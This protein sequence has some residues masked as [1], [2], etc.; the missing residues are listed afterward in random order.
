MGETPMLT[1]ESERFVTMT[2]QMHR[3]LINVLWLCVGL[4]REVILLLEKSQFH[5]RASLDRRVAAE[6]EHR[7]CLIEEALIK[8]VNCE[9]WPADD[10]E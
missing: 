6:V 1:P 4:E 3:R 9:T 7:W 8:V 10:D 2:P 5:S